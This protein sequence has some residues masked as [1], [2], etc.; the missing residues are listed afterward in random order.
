MG[1]TNE[2][3]IQ[4]LESELIQMQMHMAHQESLLQDLNT[5][6]IEQ[7]KEIADLRKDQDQMR[8]YLRSLTMPQRTN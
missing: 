5:V 3:R 4:H 2:E 1:T 8:E 7:Q 6:L